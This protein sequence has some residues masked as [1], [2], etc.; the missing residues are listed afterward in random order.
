LNWDTAIE[1]MKCVSVMGD[2]GMMMNEKNTVAFVQVSY[3][4]KVGENG[5]W[6]Q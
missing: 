5:L 3:L 6:E 2:P 4:T 1:G